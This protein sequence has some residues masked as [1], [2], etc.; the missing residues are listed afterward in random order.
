MTLSKYYIWFLE[1]NAMELIDD[2]NE[3]HSNFVDPRDLC[4][5]IAFFSNLESEQAMKQCP[6]VRH[7][8]LCSQYCTDKVKAQAGGPSVSQF[9]EASQIVAFCKK[10]DQVLQLEKTFRDLKAKYLPILE[11]HLGARVAK[12]EITAFFDLIIRSLFCR[13][14]PPLEPRVALPVGKFSEEKIQSLAVHW[15][16]VVDTKHPTLHFCDPGELGGQGGRGPFQQAGSATG[17]PGT[18]QKE[19][20]GKR[21]AAPA[22]NGL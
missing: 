14:W 11:Q 17:W 13:A 12:L 2:V 3:F 18:P 16:K 21:R 1:N 6:Q 22:L 7:F 10:P 20:V 4:V 8:L 9:L 15:A 5:S 19:Q